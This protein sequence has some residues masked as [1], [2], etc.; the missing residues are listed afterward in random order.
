MA[1]IVEMEELVVAMNA[2]R[3]KAAKMEILY[4]QVVVAA[5]TNAGHKEGAAAVNTNATED[6]PQSGPWG[7]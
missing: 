7:A 3:A 5:G 6:A 2:T 1:E 4:K